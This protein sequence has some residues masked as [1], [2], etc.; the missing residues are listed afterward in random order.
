MT[1]TDELLDEADRQLQYIEAY[2]THHKISTILPEGK[3]RSGK[4]E[5]QITFDDGQVVVLD[6]LPITL[7]YGDT[8]TLNF[9]VRFR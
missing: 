4:I 5:S 8:L 2:L 3:P 1:D 6:T 9:T 7:T